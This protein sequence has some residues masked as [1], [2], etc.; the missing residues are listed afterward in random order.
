MKDFKSP[1]PSYAATLRLQIRNKP[2]MLGK[3]TSIIGRIGGDIGA[4]DIVSASHSALVR[5]ITVNARDER[6]TRE[7]IKKIKSLS[8]VRLL[9]YSDRTF[10][11]HQGGKIEIRPKFSLKTRDSLSMAYTPGVARISEAIGKEKSK[12]WQLTIKR[13]CVAIVSD[14]TAILGLGD[15]GPEAALPVMEGKAMLFKEF[16]NIDAFPICLATKDPKEIVETVQRISPVF[17]GINLEDI[18]SPRCF[19]IEEELKKRLDIPVFH[20][21]QHGTAIVILAALMNALKLVKKRLSKIKVVVLGVGAAGTACTKILLEAGVKNII[22]CDKEGIIARRQTHG[23]PYRTWYAEHTNPD[24]IEGKLSDAIKRA[25]VFIGLSSGG[26]LNAADVKKM[27]RDAV[28]FALANPTSEIAPEEA[29]RYARIVA[30]GRSDYPNQ[31]NNALAF[32]GIFRG[33]LDCRAKTINE[34]M[35]IA[36]AQA[37]AGLVSTSELSEDYIIPSIFNPRVA[38]DVANFVKKA[39]IRTKVGQREIREP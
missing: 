22:G 16:A 25:D 28:V 35:K 10:L 19:E 1:S 12:V 3:I 13:N 23:N 9:N 29:M 21:D 8:G 30:T 5:D 15:L 18:S 36:A 20:D 33:A 2:G 31:I 26:K 17:G 11:L 32:P 37:L 39:A 38:N 7:I 6:H 14:G 27:S 24:Q 4:V 34:P